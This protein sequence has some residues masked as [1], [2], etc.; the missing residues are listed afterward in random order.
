MANAMVSI[1]KI[2]L[3]SAQSSITFANLPQNF[4]DLRLVCFFNNIAA[5]I[6]TIYFNNDTIWA[7]YSRVAMYGDGTTGQPSSGSD[8]RIME[9]SG[10]AVLTIDLLDYSVTDKHKSGLARGNSASFQVRSTGFRWFNTSAINSIQLLD[11]FTVGS[12][13]ELF[14]VSA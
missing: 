13:F 10:Y 4:R 8:P 9:S 12:T 7:N 1:G 5:G 11:S 3:T 6:E 14:G 2:T